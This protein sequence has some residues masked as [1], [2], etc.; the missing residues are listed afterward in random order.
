VFQGSKFEVQRSRFRVRTRPPAGHYE[1]GFTLLEVLISLTILSLIF[2]AVLG[3]IQVGAKSWES[4]EARA[5]EN[6]RNRSLVDILARDL[7]MIYPLRVKAQ[8]MDV[9]AFHGKSDS[10]EFATLPQVFG[11]EPFSHMIRIVA[12]AVEFDRG[13]VATGSYPLATQASVALED[14]VKPLDERVSAVRFRYLVPEGRP[15]EN[16]TPTWRDFWDPAQDVT[17]QPSSRG[18]IAPQGQRALRGSDRLPL[19][20]ELTL[21]I[22]QTKSPEARELILPPLVFPVQVGRTL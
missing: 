2:V 3:A 20:V 15:E 22:R 1:A 12:Y 14:S 21:T 5:E 7:A 16:L 19:A 17:V 9:I 10:L 8:D 11:A 6:Q 4:G 13:L 18:F